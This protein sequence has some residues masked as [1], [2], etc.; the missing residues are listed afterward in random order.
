VLEFPL[1][2][3][4]PSLAELP[5]GNRRDFSFWSGR[6]NSSLKGDLWPTFCRCLIYALATAA[7]L[8]PAPKGT[9]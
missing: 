1:S 2:V 6:A 4:A 7:T 8:K 5:P 3:G 9:A